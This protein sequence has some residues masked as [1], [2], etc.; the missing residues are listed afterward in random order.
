MDK[1]SVNDIY[2]RYWKIGVYGHYKIVKSLKERY[3]QLYI[4][5]TSSQ[6][7]NQKYSKYN[8]YQNLHDENILGVN[9]D[10]NHSNLDNEND[11]GGFTLTD[12][13][14]VLGVKLNAESLALN[15]NES[16]VLTAEVGPENAT[17]KVVRWAS[18]NLEVASVDHSGKVTGYKEGSATITAITE[19]GGYSSSCK[20]AVFKPKAGISL[21][22]TETII[23]VGESVRLIAMVS[24]NDTNNR[25]VKWNSSNT[26]I[27][28]IDESGKVTTLKSGSV[29]ITASTTD[30]GFIA[31]CNINIS[32]PAKSLII[33]KTEA[34]TQ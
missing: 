14:P 8:I 15:L 5:Q 3:P 30:G 11:I 4:W 13:I 19:D 6:S 23:N 33:D 34:I 32:Q 25:N 31:L 17:T 12:T 16:A 10:V 18:D 21:D 29:V 26:D 7:D 20:V 1:F 22:L 24:L 27:A 28:T 9:I 2:K